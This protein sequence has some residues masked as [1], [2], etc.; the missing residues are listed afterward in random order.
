MMKNMNRRRVR[1]R[2]SRVKK[3]KMKF[4]SVLVIMI[5]AI[6]LGYGTAKFV[7]GPILGFDTDESSINIV[8]KEETEANADKDTE[9]DEKESTEEGSQAK[10]IEEGYALQFGAFSTKDGAQKLVAS[11]KEKGVE[12]EIIEEDNQYKVISPIIKTKDEALDKLN[13]IKDKNVE[14]VFIASF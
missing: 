10:D 11:L 8:Q 6:A 4:V 5:L 1:K 2:P 12:A 9:E 14:D 13:D 7:I 3:T